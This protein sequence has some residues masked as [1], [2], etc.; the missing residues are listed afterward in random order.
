MREVQK[1]IGI[2]SKRRKEREEYRLSEIAKGARDKEINEAT[3]YLKNCEFW[4]DECNKDFTAV[5]FKCVETDWSLAGWRI[6]Y[7]K[8][9]CPKGHKAI[10]RITD[11]PMDPYFI[12]SVILKKQRV[13]YKK[14]LLQETDYGFNML[15]SN[16]S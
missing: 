9:K 7:Y 13:D 3:Q 8:G 4:C 1:L 5:G 16:E 14:D 12:K 15:Y 6:A 2:L 10:R 11:K